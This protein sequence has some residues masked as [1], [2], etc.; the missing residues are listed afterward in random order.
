MG[1]AVNSNDWSVIVTVVLDAESLDFYNAP[2][3]RSPLGLQ[4]QFEC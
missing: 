1:L 4:R 3:G 2:A